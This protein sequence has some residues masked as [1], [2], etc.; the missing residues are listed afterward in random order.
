M[1]KV[2]T[3]FI[4]GLFLLVGFGC[5]VYL[6]LQLGEFSM[7]SMEKNYT[8]SA[9]FN[10]VS[11]LKPGASVEMSGVL[12]G[13]VFR[14][15]L[16]KNDQAHVTLLLKRTVKVSEDAIASI[17]TQGIIGDKYVRISQGGLDDFFADGDVIEET[18]SA[19]DLEEMVSKY[20]FGD[21]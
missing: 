12:I 5:F 3:D 17:R 11:G 16:S 15:E 4:V 8:L 1:K 21:V 13:R 9:D 2:S 6:S 7:F 18:E 20:I 14:I 19:V 10:N